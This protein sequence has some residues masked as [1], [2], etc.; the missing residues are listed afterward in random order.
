MITGLLNVAV[1]T[2]V[3]A[4]GNTVPCQNQDPNSNP[5]PTHPQM[6]FNLPALHI[7]AKL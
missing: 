5:K 2:N 3:L 1:H 4:L 7:V 6:G